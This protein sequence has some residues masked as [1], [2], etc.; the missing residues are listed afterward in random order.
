[1]K[2]L[3]CY[4]RE[5]CTWRSCEREFY[6]SKAGREE[7]I[8]QYVAEVVNGCHEYCEINVQQYAACE[9]STF[10]ILFTKK[11]ESQELSQCMPLSP[12]L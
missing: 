7:S 1:M 12:L 4:G 10:V 5:F 2:Q 9:T 8:S 6:F 11:N 3:L